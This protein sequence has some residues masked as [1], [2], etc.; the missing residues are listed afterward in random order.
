M[1]S[2]LARVGYFPA[3]SINKNKA[4]FI[5]INLFSKVIFF[6]CGIEI[7]LCLQFITFSNIFVT[8]WSRYFILS[9][10]GLTIQPSRF[11]TKSL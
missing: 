7:L 8:L 6:G 3:L 4:I 11:D 9:F 10:L 1:S 2:S 5:Q